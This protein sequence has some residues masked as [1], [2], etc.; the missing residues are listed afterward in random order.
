LAAEKILAVK[1]G[2]STDFP[3]TLSAT[4]LA[5]LP[6]LFVLADSTFVLLKWI[7]FKLNA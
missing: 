3:P 4:C 7:L 2:T 5:G 1:S 6:A